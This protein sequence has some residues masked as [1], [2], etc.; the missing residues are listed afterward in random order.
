MYFHLVTPLVRCRLHRSLACS[1]H[2]SIHPPI[3]LQQLRPLTLEHPP[4]WSSIVS[5]ATAPLHHTS[6]TNLS[7]PL[8][9]SIAFLKLM[10]G[11][12]IHSGR[13]V[14]SDSTNVCLS[15]PFL[16]QYR[17]FALP[18]HDI[19]SGVDNL[20]PVQRVR[21]QRDPRPSVDVKLFLSRRQCERRNRI[22][23]TTRKVGRVH[24]NPGFR[25]RKH[26]REIG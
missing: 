16:S 24:Q 10:N 25:E 7:I 5:P 19:H 23:R 15:P 2:T 9:P 21:I 14:V 13:R 4:W 12:P 17:R 1:V 22:F 8:S 26:R 11:A 18:P 3:P 6:S 20:E